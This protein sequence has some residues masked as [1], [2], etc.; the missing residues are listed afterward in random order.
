M[1]RSIL[2]QIL[3]ALEPADQDDIRRQLESLPM[4]EREPA[5]AHAIGKLAALGS[6]RY[7]QPAPE[8]AL[9]PTSVYGET[10][11]PAPPRSAAIPWGTVATVGVGGLLLAGLAYCLGRLR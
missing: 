6:R 10:P 11:A 9:V 1:A 2:P 3:S 4:Y 5:A 8:R 7:R